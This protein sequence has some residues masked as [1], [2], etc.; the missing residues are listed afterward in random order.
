MVINKDYTKRLLKLLESE[1]ETPL[2]TSRHIEY[3]NSFKTYLKSFGVD[4][5]KFTNKDLA[6]LMALREKSVLGTLPNEKSITVKV[7][8][9]P[10]N[11]V[12]YGLNLYNSDGQRL[13]VMDLSGKLNKSLTVGEIYSDHVEKG[14]SYPLYDAGIRLSNGKG[15]ISGETLL[16]PEQTY[17]VWNKYPNKTVISHTGEHNFNYGRKV[18]KTG[19]HT[20]INDGPVVKLETP[21]GEE[22]PMKSVT[23]FHPDMIDPKTGKLNP[24][25]W[26][27]KDIFRATIPFG[28]PFLLN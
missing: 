21:I 12:Y 20:K 28:L 3:V 15:I 17:A 2:R 25:D 1:K 4:L 7:A 11:N 14:I 5:S 24:P 27:S 13:G 22:L 16:S 19:A 18:H 26:S 8:T 6:R 9:A 10:K 23:F